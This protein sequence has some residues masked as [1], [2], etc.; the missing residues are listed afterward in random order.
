MKNAKL[1]IWTNFATDYS[2]GLAFAVAKDVEQARAMVVED[3]GYDP[4]DWGDLEIRDPNVKVVRH[5]S[6]GG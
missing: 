2:G 5:V 4:S 6:G 3:C 1:F